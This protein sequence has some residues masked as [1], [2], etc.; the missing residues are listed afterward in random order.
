MYNP[1]SGRRLGTDFPKCPR[2]CGEI[3][4]MKQDWHE[5]GGERYKS[6]C[7]KKQHVPRPRYDIRSRVWGCSTSLH[8]PEGVSLTCSSK[9]PGNPAAHKKWFMSSHDHVQPGLVG[10]SAPGH[11]FSAIQADRAERPLS[12]TLAVAVQRERWHS[13]LHTAPATFPLYG[14]HLPR[15]YIS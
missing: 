5:R 4:E 13:T 15:A 10:R 2:R 6:P 1:A 8:Q 7:L 11:P 3:I 12:R 9:Q 14:T